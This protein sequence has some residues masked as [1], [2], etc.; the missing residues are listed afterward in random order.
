MSRTNGGESP[1]SVPPPAGPR[2][3]GR[4]ATGGPPLARILHW[5]LITGGLVTIADLGSTAILQQAG[6]NPEIAS[7]V[8]VGNLLVNVLI[9]SVAG[10]RVALETGRWRPA[11]PVGLIAGLLD[12]VVVGA[13]T[14]ATAQPDA[15]TNGT[16]L[17]LLMGSL[18]NAWLGTALTA[19]SAWAGTISRRPKKGR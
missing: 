4:A 19:G 13:A 2:H 15:V 16:G 11:L 1:P 18:A 6:S 9:Y 5:G 17:D 14:A 7:P 12:G 3:P 10:A 8:Q